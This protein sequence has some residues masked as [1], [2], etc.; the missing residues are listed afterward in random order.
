MIF[1]LAMSILNIIINPDSV[2][3]QKQDPSK[4]AMRIVMALIMLTLVIPINIPNAADKSLNAYI[5]DH[6]IL[7]G[8]LYKAQDSILSEN[9]LAK[10]ILGTASDR[11]ADDMDV[12]NLR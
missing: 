10:L 7:F 1:K 2:K 5:N 12:N 9:I 11:T 3:D 4:M 8:F 6:G